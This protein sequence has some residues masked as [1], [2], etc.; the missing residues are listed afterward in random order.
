MKTLR[1]VNLTFEIKYLLGYKWYSKD[2]RLYNIYC[3]YNHYIL[4]T[5]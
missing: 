5:Y 1:S 2:I 3:L 4:L